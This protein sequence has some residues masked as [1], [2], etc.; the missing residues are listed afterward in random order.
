[1]I[2]LTISALNARK[3]IPNGSQLITDYLFAL[4]VLDFTVALV[5][6]YHLWDLL[7]W[8]TFP[9]YRSACWNMAETG[10]SWSSWSYMV[11]KMNPLR[12]DTTQKLVSFTEIGLNRWQSWM[13]FLFSAKIFTRRFLSQKEFKVYTGLGQVTCLMIIKI[14]IWPTIAESFREVHIIA[15]LRTLIR[16]SKHTIMDNKAN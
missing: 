13:K 12:P 11:Y 7:K 2:S 3:T 9:I 5:S 6:R 8:I 15:I 14:I 16:N 4:T 1:M 10:N